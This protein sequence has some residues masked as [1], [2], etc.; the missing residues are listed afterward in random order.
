MTVIMIIS[1]G[2]RET[3][4]KAPKI[5]ANVYLVKPPELEYLVLTIKALKENGGKN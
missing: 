2:I 4:F 1:H 5:G 3:A